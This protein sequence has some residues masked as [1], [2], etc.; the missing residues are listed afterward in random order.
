MVCPREA[1]DEV[2]RRI[3]VVS[4]KRAGDITLIQGLLDVGVAMAPPLIRAVRARRNKFSSAILDAP[5]GTT[6]PV[7]AAVRDAD[8]LLLVTEPTP[9]G[10]HDLELAVEM[11]RVLGLRFGVVINRVGIGDDRI[12]EFCFTQGIRILAEIPDDRRVAEISSKG[13]LIVDHLPEYR[14]L[15]Q[16]LAEEVLLEEKGSPSSVRSIRTAMQRQ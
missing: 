9:F 4:T 8:Y 11:V 3:G 14:A 7:I 2:A 5:P 16:R 12:R 10:L 6:C 15:F 13:A 1:I